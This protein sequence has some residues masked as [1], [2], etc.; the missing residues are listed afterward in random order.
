MIAPH[1]HGV[2]ICVEWLAPLQPHH[3]VADVPTKNLARMEIGSM[4]GACFAD[5]ATSAAA[6]TGE[7][8]RRRAH[9]QRVD[10]Q[11][12]SERVGGGRLRQVDPRHGPAHVRFVQQGVQHHEQV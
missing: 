9:R 2:R 6:S 5:T 3:L 7:P 12:S 11:H 10:E 1:H 8:V 4:P